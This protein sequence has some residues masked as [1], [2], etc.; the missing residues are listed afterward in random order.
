MHVL[1]TGAS[2]FLGSVCL[3]SLLATPDVRVTAL[4]SGSNDKTLPF[5]VPEI[6][7][8]EGLA[9][10]SLEKALGSD[11]PTHIIHVGALSSPELCENNPEGAFNANMR[12]TQILAG[13]GSRVGAHMIT[14]STDLVFDGAL[15]TN[16]GFTE[17]SVPSPRSIYSQSKIGAEDA[18][19]S[20]ARGAVVRLS[21][22]Y[23]HSPASSGSF[24][25]MEKAFALGEKVSLYSDEFRTPIHVRDAAAT[26]ILLSQRKMQGLWHCGGP[27]RLSRV[28]FGT[29]Y[30][31]ALG[32]DTSLI[33]PTSRLAKAHRPMRPEDV[34]LNSDKLKTT[35]GVVGKT[36][37]EALALFRNKGL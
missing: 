13:F 17:R 15:A 20:L 33:E 31:E 10:S 32:Y 14:T 3:G 18:T 11:I 26:L 36:V 24:A 16:I 29:L 34:C 19:L 7:I 37:R 21:L 23:G 2:G 28:E 9:T 30:A 12:T 35:F 8:P 6:H 22:L 25:W 27:E 1:L 4:R 5:T